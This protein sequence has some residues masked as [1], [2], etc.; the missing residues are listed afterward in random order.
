MTISVTEYLASKCQLLKYEYQ[1][2]IFT[3]HM[4]AHSLN[5]TWILGPSL[6]V[7]KMDCY[8]LAV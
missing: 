8:Y 6:D 5:V 7:C 2:I 3:Q 1:G 4:L